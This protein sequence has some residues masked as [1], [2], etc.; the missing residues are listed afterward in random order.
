[1]RKLRKTTPWNSS[2]G[3]AF[4]RLLTPIALAFMQP[5]FS[6]LCSPNHHQPAVVGR[7]RSQIQCITVLSINE[8]E[9]TDNDQKN[10]R[11]D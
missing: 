3:Q 8:Q 7:E 2:P 4:H 5:E 6:K 11:L 1:M 9:R 10:E